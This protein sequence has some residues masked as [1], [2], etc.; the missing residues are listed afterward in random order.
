MKSILSL[1]LAITLLS[2]SASA[3]CSKPVT[4]LT[5]GK[6]AVC[7]GYLFSPEQELT[8]RTIVMDYERLSKVAATQ[9]ELIGVMD[10]RLGLQTDINNN[11]RAQLESSRD[12]G[13]WGKV[14]AFGLGVVVAGTVAYMSQRK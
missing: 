5:E 8:V 4:Y 10:K 9:D 13:T 6:P 2:Q 3:L 1:I 7:T 12:A 14:I 11:L